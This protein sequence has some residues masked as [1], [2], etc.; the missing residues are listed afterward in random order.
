[1]GRLL[2]ILPL[3]LLLAG[4]GGS[5]DESDESASGEVLKT[6]QISEKEFSLN[7]NTVTLSQPGTY[8]FEVTNDGRI[9]HALEVEES[10]GG[11]EVETGDIAAG[12]SKTL[13]FT[14]SADGSYE[15]YCPIG[16]HKDEGMRGT[17]VVGSAPGGSGTTTDRTTTD[18]S[19]GY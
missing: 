11:A 7:P 18:D 3:A 12:E 2:V 14:F 13:R 1:M 10:G 8:E 16:N 17:I 6:I 19:P 15:M 5:S 4:C 9:T